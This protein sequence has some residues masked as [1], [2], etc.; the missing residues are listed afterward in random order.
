MHYFDRVESTQ[1]VA[2]ELVRQGAPDGTLV[3]AEHQTAGRGRMQREWESSEGK[4]IWMT[5]IIRPKSH[6]T[7]PRNLL[8]PQQLLL[9]M[10]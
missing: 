8:C 9:S 5:L 10:Q 7:K 6:H 3:I 2:H 1:L 4:G